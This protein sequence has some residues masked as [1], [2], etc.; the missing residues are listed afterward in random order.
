MTTSTLLATAFASTGTCVFGAARLR[1][2]RLEAHS[3]TEV[4]GLLGSLAPA[5]L[6][7]R[8]SMSMTASALARYVATIDFDRDII[9]AARDGCA[10]L[11]GI[12]QLMPLASDRH[13]PA[14]I[15]FA[16]A[17]AMQGRGLGKGLMA[18]AIAYAQMSGITLLVAQICPRNA[19]M[20]AVFQSA[21]MSLVRDDGEITGT[22]QIARGV[23]VRLSREAHSAGQRE[24]DS[25]RLH[26]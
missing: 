22:L 10:A 1:F 17:P 18:A 8:F 19:P 4:L 21:G 7:L 16:V 15:A 26:P 3:R 12:V 25:R 9:I 24:R 14:E 20:L 13:R 2:E 5:D 23:S 6:A 11:A